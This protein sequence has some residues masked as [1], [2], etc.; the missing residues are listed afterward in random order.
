MTML[1]WATL[2]R[3]AWLAQE[4]AHEGSVANWS[5][6]SF[7]LNAGRKTLGI[8]F[9]SRD[10]KMSLGLPKIIFPIIQRQAVCST[11]E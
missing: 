5:P 2:N 1:G 10:A 7:Q 6:H 11:K 3:V 4:Q 9:G 8:H